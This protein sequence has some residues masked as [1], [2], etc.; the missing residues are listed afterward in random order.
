MCAGGC[1]TVGFLSGGRDRDVG[2]SALFPEAHSL[3]LLF[4]E[5]LLL[6]FRL[7]VLVPPSPPQSA[8]NRMS[9]ILLLKL[10][11]LLEMEEEVNLFP[12]HEKTH[13]V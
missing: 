13:T 3:S 4:S 9:A 2:A 5:A 1:L 12:G 7:Q 11:K 8:Y 10:L 6:V